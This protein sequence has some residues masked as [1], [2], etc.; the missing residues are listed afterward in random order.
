M[1]TQSGVRVDHFAG[2]ATAALVRVPPNICSLWSV[3]IR[4]WISP[5]FFF[6]FVSEVIRNV[7]SMYVGGACMDKFFD[8]GLVGS[9]VAVLLVRGMCLVFSMLL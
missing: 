2:A 8:M 9:A 1:S 7:Y 5:L 3:T 6:I 4:V